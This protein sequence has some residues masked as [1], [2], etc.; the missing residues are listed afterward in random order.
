MSRPSAMHVRRATTT[1]V[2]ALVFALPGASDAAI[3]AIIAGPGA[4]VPPVASYSTPIAITR[5]GGPLRFLNA[6]PTA[7]HD[8]VSVA[9]RSAT[10]CARFASRCPVFFSDLVG[11]G[12]VSEVSLVG[13]PGGS[14]EFFC[15]LHPAM[16]GTLQIV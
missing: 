4:G 5:T 7:F 9:S 12:E 1:A 10:P 8:V 16:R 6:D 15:T 2:V 3:S 13:V 14:Y 11:V